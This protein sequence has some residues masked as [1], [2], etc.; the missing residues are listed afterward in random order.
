MTPAPTFV[1]VHGAWHGGWCWSRLA[2]RLQAKG[3]KVYT[4]TLT[5]LGER[6]HLL[7]P[8]I[9]LRIDAY[10]PVGDNPWP[11]ADRLAEVIRM[12]SIAADWIGFL[13][14]S[15]PTSNWSAVR[16]CLPG[17]C[18]TVTAISPSRTFFSAT[19]QY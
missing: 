11:A 1:L 17:L 5:G 9:T 18:S 16:I 19:S 8:D 7:S 3:H 4:P 12:G 2:A 10:F 14:L 13:F 15:S 6:S